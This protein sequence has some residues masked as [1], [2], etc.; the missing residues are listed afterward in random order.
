[1]FKNCN[2]LHCN[3]Y[4]ASNFSYNTIATCYDKNSTNF[5][6]FFLNSFPFLHNVGTTFACIQEK[7][8]QTFTYQAKKW[9]IENK[10]KENPMLGFKN[11][12]EK[13]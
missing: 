6:F 5:V 11:G 7:H 10:R 3:T 8:I 4:K 2:S 13:E 9:I 12:W 1:M